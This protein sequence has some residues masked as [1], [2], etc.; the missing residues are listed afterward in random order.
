MDEPNRYG[1]RS[2]SRT[3][4]EVDPIAFSLRPN[5]DGSATRRLAVPTIVD[6]VRVPQATVKIEFRHQ[7]RERRTGEWQDPDWFDLRD[8]EPGEEIRLSL[9]SEETLVL[10]RRLGELYAIG[11][12]GV[13]YGE[14]T[15]VVADAEDATV[16]VGR[17]RQVIEQLVSENGPGLW[18][19]IESIQPDLLTAA[20]AARVRQER[21]AAVGDFEGHVAAGD[22]AEGAWQDFFERNTWIFGSGLAYQFLR[23]VQA[24]PNFGG[25]TITGRG[26][27]RGDYMMATDASVR[28]AVLVEIKRPTSGLVG[29]EYRNGVHALGEDLTGGVSQLQINCRTWATEGSRTEGN[30]EL[31]RQAGV[32]TVQPKGILVIGNTGQLDVPAKV[33]TFELF[34]QNLSNPEIIT[35]DE[36]LIRARYLADAGP[37]SPSAAPRVDPPAAR[38]EATPIARP[39][40]ASGRPAPRHR[41]VR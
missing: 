23:S 41:N 20:H 22:W 19:L 5:P 40:P 10:Y 15:L 11:E 37:D 34:R 26:G 17:E 38:P 2:T 35:F 24:Q 30:A 6:N 13:P 7:R 28:F 3:S 31:M 21:L 36:L 39:R 9:S 14:R 27:Q 29:D 33:R 1:I 18:D 25:A 16:L 32:E 8:L 12:R 4:A